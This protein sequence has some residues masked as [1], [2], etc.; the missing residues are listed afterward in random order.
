M[1]VLELADRSLD[2]F[3]GAQSEGAAMRPRGIRSSHVK[4]LPWYYTDKN[5]PSRQVEHDRAL[6]QEFAA[7]TDEV[8]EWAARGLPLAVEAW[9]ATETQV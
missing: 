6:A 8:V 7:F 4:V 9:Q 3:V 2:P 5:Q 1:P